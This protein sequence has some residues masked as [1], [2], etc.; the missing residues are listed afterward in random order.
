MVEQR[1][2]EWWHGIVGD[3]LMREEVFVRAADWLGRLHEAV[4][5]DRVPLVD[6]LA[7]E[8]VSGRAR[9]VSFTVNHQPWMP[10]PDLPYVVAIVEIVDYLRQRSRPYLFSNALPP[11]MAMIS[12]PDA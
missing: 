9:V 6:R 2:C 11:P 4:G 5:W 1:G 7:P 10:G 3:L 8:A 12:R